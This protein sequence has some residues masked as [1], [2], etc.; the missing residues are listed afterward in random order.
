MTPF[1]ARRLFRAESVAIL[2]ALFLSGPL[3]RAAEREIHPSLAGQLRMVQLRVMSGRVSAGGPPSQQ[4]LTSNYMGN[5]RREQL[6]LDLGGGRPSVNYERSAPNERLTYLI[7][8]GNEVTI[9]LVPQSTNDHA[10]VVFVQPSEGALRLTVTTGNHMKTVYA[11]S[12]WHLLIFE[13]RLCQ[14][15]L[16]P[17]LEIV[18]PDWQLGQQAYEIENALCAD[19]PARPVVDQSAW[20][21]NLR[22]LT[23]D[24]FIERER[25]E[26]QLLGYGP[27]VLPF[28]RGQ[29]VTT[30]DA[31]QAFRVRRVLRG[32]A[33]DADEDT[34]DRVVP[35]LTGDPRVWYALLTRDN[36]RVRSIAAGQLKKLLDAEFTFDPAA[37]PDQ[38]RMEIERLHERFGAI[39]DPPSPASDGE[40]AE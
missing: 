17:L 19:Q 39:V 3:V 8:D 40:K 31:E 33:K 4:S 2:L 9:Q 34:T 29:V 6:T 36:V 20:E 10:T 24:R 32:L 35:W 11:A 21:K 25:A 18:R 7:E 27:V 13:P 16:L 22:Q 14:E 23:S 26:Q 38:R 15:Y 37:Q 12:L 5:Q 30:L 1:A 28:L